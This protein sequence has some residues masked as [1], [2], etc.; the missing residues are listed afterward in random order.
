MIVRVYVKTPAELWGL[1]VRQ[2]VPPLDLAKYLA[3][4]AAS[5]SASDVR[6]WSEA[7]LAHDKSSS[8]SP[9][10]AKHVAAG[11]AFMIKFI[12][13]IS[14]AEYGA[15]DVCKLC[16]EG[17]LHHISLVYLYAVARAYALKPIVQ[18]GEYRGFKYL[19]VAASE[20][21]L[22]EVSKT[23]ELMIEDACGK[24]RLCR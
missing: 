16:V 21:G 3:W 19:I 23:L 6:E 7:V 5:N 12:V 20:A 10:T 14:N 8:I 2:G 13:S 22:P 15:E 9:E 1:A 24:T 18:E 17:V 11:F 4:G